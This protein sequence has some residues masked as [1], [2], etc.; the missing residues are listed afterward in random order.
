MLRAESR[1]RIR[2]IGLDESDEVVVHVDLVG[3]HRGE[4]AGSDE[5]RVD[6]AVVRSRLCPGLPDRRQPG[7]GDR[8]ARDAEPRPPNVQILATAA[9]HTRTAE[10]TYVTR[11]GVRPRRR[12][13][14]SQAARGSG[15]SKGTCSGRG[16]RVPPSQPAQDSNRVLHQYLGAAR[17]SRDRAAR[18]SYRHGPESAED[19]QN[20][21]ESPPGTVQ[22]ACSQPRPPRA[23]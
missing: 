7:S 19:Q 5:T 15:A 20:A 12:T 16:R 8:L 21:M 17:P 11:C 9:S 22:R 2:P 6:A 10:L 3:R 23:S 1:H 18:P 4:A 14:A 13:A